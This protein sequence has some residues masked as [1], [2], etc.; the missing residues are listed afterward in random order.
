MVVPPC[1]LIPLIEG[2]EGFVNVAEYFVAVVE[3]HSE[4]PGTNQK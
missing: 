2:E 4:G 1:S 3:V